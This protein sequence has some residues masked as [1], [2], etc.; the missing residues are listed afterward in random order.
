MT[1]LIGPNGSGKTA[2][3]LA[4][5]RMFGFNPSMRRVQRSDFHVSVEEEQSP[6]ER[7][8]WIEAE[9]IFPELVEGKD[10]SA[11]P[12]HFGHMR[13]DAPDLPPRVRYRLTATMGIDGD[14]DESFNYV[15]EIDDDNSPLNCAKVSRSERNFI[16]VHYL[17]AK[18]DPAEHVAYGSNAI[19]GDCYALLNGQMN[20]ILFQTD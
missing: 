18:R 2:A 20:A 19:L 13:L 11:V 9:F 1:Y 7:T 10:S 15:L 6:E 16:Q 17:P 3:L 12:P 4:L 5:G 14:I 8:L